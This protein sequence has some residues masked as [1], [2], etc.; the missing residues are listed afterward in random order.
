MGN[1]NIKKSTGLNMA[2]GQGDD[3]NRVKHS[4]PGLV[5]HTPKRSAVGAEPSS[6]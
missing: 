3:V 6:S 5:T 4:P 2:K 1:T